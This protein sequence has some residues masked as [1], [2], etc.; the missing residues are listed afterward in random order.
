[1]LN[2]NGAPENIYLPQN[3]MVMEEL[4]KKICEINKDRKQLADG[5]NKSFLIGNYIKC[6]WLRSQ[7]AEI[8]E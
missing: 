3:E 1:M 2:Q 5:R 8:A 7:K 6:K 4:N